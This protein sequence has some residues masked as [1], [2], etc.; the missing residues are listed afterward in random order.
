ML[1][2]VVALDKNSGSSSPIMAIFHFL[3]QIGANIAIAISSGYFLWYGIESNSELVREKNWF[4]NSNYH[5]ET[6]PDGIST[7]SLDQNC[8]KVNV[9]DRFTLVL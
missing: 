2:P 7:I 3:V 9:Y 5:Y 8:D 1:S 6:S 4:C